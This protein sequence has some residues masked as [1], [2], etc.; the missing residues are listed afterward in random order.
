MFWNLLK[1]DVIAHDS[2]SNSSIDIFLL[3]ET[4]YMS[5]E[6]DIMMNILVRG[7]LIG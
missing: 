4:H 5:R 3:V 6:Y 2:I 1:Y 7:H